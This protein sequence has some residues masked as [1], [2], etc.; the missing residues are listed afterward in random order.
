V[1]NNLSGAA[2]VAPASVD[3]VSNAVVLTLVA[4]ALGVLFFVG[5]TYLPPTLRAS[6]VWLRLRL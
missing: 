4:L 1:F 5:Y 3:E 6:G 2:P